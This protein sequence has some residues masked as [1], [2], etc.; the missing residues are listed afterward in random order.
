MEVTLSTPRPPATQAGEGA[1]TS[2]SDRL[3]HERGPTHAANRFLLSVYCPTCDT[4]FEVDLTFAGFTPQ[5]GF[6]NVSLLC[7][8]PDVKVGYSGQDTPRYIHRPCGATLVPGQAR[9]VLGYA[10]SPHASESTRRE[11]RVSLVARCQEVIT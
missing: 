1:T 8:T 4:T 7:R 11:I 2:P 6:R 10:T 5:P 3:R 9:P